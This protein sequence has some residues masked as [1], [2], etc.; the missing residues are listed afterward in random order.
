M[1]K[2]TQW[3]ENMIQYPDLGLKI[4]RVL[5]R[6]E[7]KEVLR[8]CGLCQRAGSL[9]ISPSCPSL[10]HSSI[11]GTLR[12]WGHLSFHCYLVI[13]GP[14]LH[15]FGSKIF[16]W[17]SQVYEIQIQAK[18]RH[19]NHICN[20]ICLFFCHICGEKLSGRTDTKAQNTSKL[21]DDI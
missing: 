18:L 4:D 3:G 1:K 2:Y 11:C 8:V 16:L 9:T 14:Q 20:P 13:T 5:A 10:I 19:L 21:N 15:F 17:P 12:S 6:V 7:S